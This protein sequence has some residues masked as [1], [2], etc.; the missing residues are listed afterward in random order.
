MKIHIK[1][2]DIVFYDGLFSQYLK[3]V[4]RQAEGEFKMDLKQ[5]QMA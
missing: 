4:W 1:G 5:N 3:N 2:M